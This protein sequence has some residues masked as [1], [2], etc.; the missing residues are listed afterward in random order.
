MECPNV[1][2]KDALPVKIT[3]T[4]NKIGYN[5]H[6]YGCTYT[7]SAL[8]RIIFLSVIFPPQYQHHAILNVLKSENFGLCNDT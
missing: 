2:F 6:K 1:L 7:K 5:V 3:L 8:I 4:M